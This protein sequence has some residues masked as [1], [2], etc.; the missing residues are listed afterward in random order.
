METFHTRVR[1]TD[2]DRARLFLA[3]ARRRIRVADLVREALDS[4]LTAEADTDSFF[5]ERLAREQVIIQ[6]TSDE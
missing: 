2:E 4:V 5:D 1:G 3:A 6:E